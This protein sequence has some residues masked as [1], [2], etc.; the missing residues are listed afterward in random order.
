[1]TDALVLK[2]IEAVK[3]GLI[4][5]YESKGE[6]NN[7][8]ERMAFAS[9]QSGI[10]LAQTGLGSVHGLAS[11]L[12]A[13]FPIPHGIV[14]GTLLSEATKINLKALDKR[15]DKA[16]PALEKYA[17]LAI[18]MTGKNSHQA[19][20]DLLEDWTEKLNLP[21]LKSFGLQESDLDRI[22]ENSRGSSMKTNSIVLTDSEI[23]LIL[24]N[25]M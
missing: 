21:R 22:V 17:H 8:R 5:L 15:A 24:E 18:L 9:L 10:C 13:F 19:L 14:C 7:A 11:P 23:R 4:S 12:G 1:M 16:N 6:D 25:R 20:I 3:E 2:G